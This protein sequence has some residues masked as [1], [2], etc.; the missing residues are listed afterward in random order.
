[1]KEFKGEILRPYPR[2]QDDKQKRIPLAMLGMI[3]DHFI[4][5][6]NSLSPLGR[7]LVF[8]HPETGVLGFCHPEGCFFARRI[9]VLTLQL[10]GMADRKRDPSLRSG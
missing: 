1:M 4:Q 2:P 3:R 7:C 6:D 5:E 9:S 8:C 10:F